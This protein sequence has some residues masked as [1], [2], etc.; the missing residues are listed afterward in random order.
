MAVSKT[1]RIFVAFPRWDDQPFTVAEIVDGRPVPYPSR[2]AND[3]DRDHP[4]EKLG[5]VEALTVASGDLWVLDS[6]R[7][8]FDA[9]ISGAA[10]LLRI[11]LESDRILRRWV[12]PERVV[13]KWSY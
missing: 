8:D 6:G 1:G 5:S 7:P 3:F 13:R 4:R 2:A 11:D 12:V 10:K 9:R